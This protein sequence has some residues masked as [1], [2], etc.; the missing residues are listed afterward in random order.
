MCIFH[1]LMILMGICLITLALESE[2]RRKEKR[3]DRAAAN[4][5]RIRNAEFGMRNY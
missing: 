5:I 2:Q 3:M 4:I 1:W